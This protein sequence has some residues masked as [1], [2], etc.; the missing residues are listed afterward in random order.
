MPGL[1]KAVVAADEKVAETTPSVVI[2]KPP[3]AVLVEVERKTLFPET[4]GCQ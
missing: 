3:V 1:P 2:R 4:T